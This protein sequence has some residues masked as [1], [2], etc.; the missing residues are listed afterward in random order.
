VNVL[1]RRRDRDPVWPSRGYSLRSLAD[2]LSFVAPFLAVYALFL[3]APVVQAVYISG[4]KWDLLGAEPI[5]V[6]FGNYTR[7]FG[8]SD[9]VWSIDYQ[10]ASR[11]VL[12]LGGAA[13]AYLLWRGGTSRVGAELTLGAIFVFAFVLGFHPSP[14]GHWND[15]VFWVSLQ[16]TIYFTILNTPLLVGLGLGLAL[17]L[18]EKRTRALGFYRAIFF[19]PYVLPISAVTLIWTFLLDPDRGLIGGVLRRFGNDGINFLGDPNLAMPAIVATSVWW[20]VGFTLVLFLAGLQDIEPNLY[21]AAELDGAGYWRRFQHIT[22]PGLRHV[23]VLVAVTQLIASFQI[24]GQVYIMT[25]GGPGTATIV[26]IE[27]IYE[28]GFKNYQLGFAA[29]LSLV[30]FLLMTAA[31]AVQFRLVARET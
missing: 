8:G 12:L 20:G 14:A 4:F 13:I 18:H 29:A 22:L 30:I 28:A 6:G 17:L 27:H 10:W 26:F 3:L 16:N 25:R 24:F 1:L 2:G 19:L 23:T 15:P 21:E 31:A 7:M 5:F 9:I 11:L